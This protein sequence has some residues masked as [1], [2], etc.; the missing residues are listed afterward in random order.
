MAN[1]FGKLQLSERRELRF[2]R[3]RPIAT[4]APAVVTN[5]GELTM[6]APLQLGLISQV[7]LHVADVAEAERFYGEVLGLPHLYTFGSLAFFDCDGTRLFLS[8]NEADTHQGG[9][10][11]TSRSRRSTLPTTRSATAVPSSRGRR[12]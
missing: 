12:T 4:I 9:S 6:P 2:W 7:S 11:P 5:V 3:G 10:I 1:I 8:A